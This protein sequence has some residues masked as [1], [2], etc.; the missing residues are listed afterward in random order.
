MLR[1]WFEYFKHAHKTTFPTI[2]GFVRRR[3]RAI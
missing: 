3:M 1:G 2:D